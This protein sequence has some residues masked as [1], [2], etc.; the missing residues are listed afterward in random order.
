MTHAAEI[1]APQPQTST[2]LPARAPLLRE[3]LGIFGTAVAARRSLLNIVPEIATRQLMI[4]GKTGVR[5]HMVMAP[6]AMRRVLKDK[7]DDYP[8]S[9]ITKLILKPAVGDSLF[10]TEGAHWRWQRR[11]AAPVFAQRHVT[12]LGVVM[13]AAAEA[14]SRRLAK[15]TGPVD[16]LEETVAATFEV[17]ADVTFSGEGGLDRKVVHDAVNG[18][19]ESAAKTSLLDVVGA[20]SWIPRPGRIIANASLRRMKRQANQA[21]ADRAAAAEQ[22]GPPDLLDLLLEAQDP[23]TQRKMTHTELRDNLLAFIVA[24]HETTAL[25]LAWALYLCSFDPAVQERA[26]AEAQSVLGDRTATAADVVNLPYIDRVVHETLRLYPPG[27]FLARTALAHDELCGREILPRDTIMMPIY[28]MHR[29]H[30]LWD[31]PDAFDPDRFLTPPDRFAFLPFGGGPRICIGASFALQ[32]CVIILSTLL[33]R[34][35]FTAIPGRQ[36]EPRVILTL[37]PHGG[38]WLNVEPR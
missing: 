37:R 30:M 1:D 19:I 28:A 14:S 15:A 29:H 21:I 27:S 2:A 3:P 33:A 36:P 31:N 4:S 22:H 10:G 11:A 7:L 32:E 18:Y 12:A 34:F 8:K 23:E 38:V 16:I 35:R 26:A 13:T 5:W 20:P 24:G 17:I 9:D 25:T 6:E